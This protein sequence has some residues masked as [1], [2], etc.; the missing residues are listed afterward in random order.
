M[1]RCCINDFG[2]DPHNLPE[3]I[4]ARM[5]GDERPAIRPC[6]RY[7]DLCQKVCLR[8]SGT[9]AMLATQAGAGG[10]PGPS[11]PGM[12]DTAAMAGVVGYLLST[13]GMHAPPP[14]GA[15]RLMQL[16]VRTDT[17][18]PS[19]LHRIEPNSATPPSEFLAR[20]ETST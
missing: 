11:R 12:I 18:P 10:V 9:G 1:A 16:H 6:E 3:D 19:Y 2:A 15:T 14:P 17:G 20:G 13:L 8:K 5:Y 7:Y 4:F